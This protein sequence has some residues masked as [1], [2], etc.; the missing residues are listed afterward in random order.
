[1]TR[2]LEWNQIEP[3]L[4]QL[5]DAAPGQ[6]DTELDRLSA[7]DPELRRE[8][9]TLLRSCEHGDWYVDTPAAIFLAPIIAE[10][11][12]PEPTR[13]G[14]L[15]GP[16][17]VTRELGRGGM[18]Q[19]YLAERA[20][21][22]FEQQVALKLIRRGLDSDEVQRRFLAERRILARLSHPNVARLLDGGMTAEG[23][24]W[25]ALEYVD[26]E[27]IL[28][29]AERRQLD[30]PARISL[31]LDVCDAV[32]YAHQHLVVHRDLKPSNILVTADGQAKLLDFGIAKML[33]DQ[34]DEAGL[35]RTGLR[36]MT[37]EYASPEQVRGEPVTTATDVYAL[38]AV[39]YE[40]LSGQAAHQFRRG[41]AAEIEWTICEV[42]PEPP[43]SAADRTGHP[44]RRRQ[45]AGDL[46]T[47]ILKALH[48][49]PARRYASVDALVEDLKRFQAGLPVAARPDTLRYRARKYLRR[50]RVPVLAVASVLLIGVAGVA[51]LLPL[52]NRL[53]NA[54]A[55]ALLPRIA[56]L[57]EQGRYVE[58]YQ[59]AE[60]A[61]RRLGA[62]PRLARLFQLVADW[63]T[64][65]TTPPGA[66][67]W[68]QRFTLADSGGRLADSLIVGTTP[69]RELRV[70]R[71]DYRLVARLP[72]FVAA[73]RMAS[74]EAN[75]VQNIRFPD[76]SRA[77]YAFKLAR[78]DSVPPGMVPVTGGRYELVSPS[79]P[80]GITGE[81]SDFLIDRTEVANA[82]YQ[83]FVRANGYGVDSLW[84][85]GDRRRMVDRSGRPGPRGWSGQAP[86]GATDHPVT[87]VSW[88]E[89][90]AF[91]AWRGAT[92]PTLLEW[93]KVA[94]NGEITPVGTMMPW[95]HAD[96]GT[97]LRANF[98]SSGPRAVDAFP[99]GVSPWG[100]LNMAG[101]VKEW[102]LNRLGSG[103]VAAGGSWEDQ[104]Y[105]FSSYGEYP[106][107]AGSRSIGFR[108][109]RIAGDLKD[110]GA[111][112]LRL[113]SMTP[114]YHP[115]DDATF[116]TFLP[117]YRYDPPT[118]LGA[119]TIARL[120][121]PDWIR[122][123]VV[124]HGIGRDS[125]LAYLYL[126]SRTVA[127]FQTLVY[128][129]AGNVFQGDSLWHDVEVILPDVIRSGRALLAP[130][131]EGMTEREWPVD[132]RLPLPQTV[133]FRDL[134]IRHSTE[135][136]IGL[137][138][139]E[140]RPE[141]DR[142]RF[143]YVGASWGA[144]SRL[145]LAGTDD[146]W[147]ALI[148]IA[149]G[150][151]ERVHPTLPEASNINFAPRLRTPK[152]MLNGR[153]DEEHPWLTRALPL[154]NLL[155]E[156]KDLVLVEGAGHTPPQS[157]L[158]PA[159]VTWLDRILGPVQQSIEG[160]D[161][162]RLRS[163]P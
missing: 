151:D 99:F 10:S 120:E 129:P 119:R 22:Q 29:Y 37:P 95:G 57:A 136:R 86:D 161:R 76:P 60:E 122:E 140:T 94:R 24:P 18:G 110:R 84:P 78:E 7:G 16:Y 17:R 2:P 148:L 14:K 117:F 52:R 91:C 62:D 111:A 65:E 33:G 146:R 21:G 59:L 12:E 36:V 20:D 82:A 67:V 143:V 54:R 41:T 89:A 58:G 158:V 73:E 100:A 87:G 131:L 34:T 162:T 141:I 112:P 64:F 134:M 66:R 113:D 47:M 147:R 44:E 104:K 13:Q 114:V 103:R 53:A 163:Q 45:L 160:P 63:L 107:E 28:D 32:R 92:L 132:F 93:E 39:L 83:E 101:N 157:A 3:L 137:D 133:G 150:I 56:E 144:G 23:Q 118:P 121:S 30:V 31:F 43:S 128:V 42:D 108:C 9:E 155:P 25:F 26:G 145:V 153:L 70:A 61:E 55:E 1:M 109:V 149:A 75:R 35:T 138:Y 96:E 102:T 38:G 51:V 69:V 40:L 123:K 71:G 6:R 4:D 159:M 81:L 77:S 156:P 127:P 154:W 85:E 68:L 5:L 98:I 97:A 126:P 8:L 46:D 130:V 152:L 105:V 80:R 72:G 106:A 124:Y 49:D 125:L 27:P 135:L 88:F 50:Y 15:V 79:M 115:V 90:R 48:K 74:T 139:L 142:T 116:R 11:T 19:V